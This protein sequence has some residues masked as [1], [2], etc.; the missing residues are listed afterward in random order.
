[1]VPLEEEEEDVFVV[2]VAVQVVGLVVDS[3]PVAAVMLVVGG[4]GQ[5][6]LNYTETRN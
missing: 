3:M 5:Q 4:T 1:M 2:V 6:S